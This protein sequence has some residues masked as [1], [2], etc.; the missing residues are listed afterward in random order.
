VRQLLVRNV[1]H[2]RPLRLVLDLTDVA[3]IGWCGK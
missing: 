3:T 2:E 1:R